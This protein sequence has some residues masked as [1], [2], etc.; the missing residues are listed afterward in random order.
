MHP[1]N[2]L[3]AAAEAIALERLIAIVRD[4]RSEHEARLA[5]AAI[6]AVRRS[7][8]KPSHQPTVATLPVSAREPS[9]QPVATPE[10]SLAAPLTP[11][12][13]EE[14]SLILPSVRPERFRK[15]HR[16]AHWRAV[17]AEQRR[18]RPS[19]APPTPRAR[20]A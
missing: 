4:S 20:A 6:F 14:L 10:P 9:P 11:A 1:D 15:P 19:A 13:L 3:L 16:A 2:P 7:L 8:P 5:A 18:L 17:L 12:E